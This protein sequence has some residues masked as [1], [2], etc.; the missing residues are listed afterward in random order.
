MSL[1]PD[2]P[3]GRRL[4]PSA[5]WLLPPLLVALLLL[6]VGLGASFMPPG[7]VLEALAGAG[8][9][10]DRVIVWT[11][12]LP[13]VLMAMLAGAALALAGLLLQR[14]TRNPLAAQTTLGVVDGAAL[15]VLLFLWAFSNS[16]DDLTVS[17]LWQPA[18]AALG[19][20]GFATAVALLARRDGAG[21]L[22]L[23]LYGIALGRS[24]T[25]WPPS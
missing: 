1:A 7:R 18:A 24:R 21:P 5:A 2:L 20:A 12:R 19:A 9:R 11:L 25:R 10:S 4:S 22:R 13:R 14:A 17:V 16:A 8:E 6:G 23:I 3:S 15:G